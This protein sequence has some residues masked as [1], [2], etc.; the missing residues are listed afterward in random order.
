MKCGSGMAR[1]Y[2]IK[3][4]MMATVAI[5]IT[6]I[7]VVSSVGMIYLAYQR[8]LESL[9]NRGQLLARVQSAAL[10]NP[11]WE[12]NHTKVQEFLTSL[13][14]DASFRSAKVYDPDYKIVAS[15]G[16]D[17]MSTKDFSFMEPI[18]HAD[19]EGEKQTIGFLQIVLSQD[20]LMREEIGEII[21][22]TLSFL[23]LLI[24]TMI[25]I[26]IAFSRII[27]AP[28]DRVIRTIRQMAG[29][30][31]SHRLPHT[32]HK[33]FNQL[34]EA[35]NKI[36]EELQ[37]IYETIEER[38]RTLEVTIQ[39][40]EMA[41]IEAETANRAKSL[42]LANMSHELRTPLNAI[43]GYSEILQ[44]ESQGMTEGEIK[45]D[46]KKIT[47]S[48][49]HLLMLINDVLDVSKIEAGKMTLHVEPFSVQALAQEAYSIVKPM[50]EKNQNKLEI[51]IDKAVQKMESDNMKVKQILVNLL[52]NAAK[53]TMKG[54]VKLMIKPKKIKKQS[55][56]EFSV[57]DTGI[58][59]SK[60]QIEKVFSAFVQ[61]DSSTTR[62]FG[63]FG[64]GLT[65]TKEFCRIL[66]GTISVKSTPNKGSIFTV[67]LPFSYKAYKNSRKIA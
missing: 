21:N 32:E 23:M 28:L 46:L 19:D 7:M 18:I 27:T 34:A 36:T 9:R 37:N 25:A 57:K 2:S 1:V 24:A 39:A 15:I 63:G 16:E 30:D 66:G 20:E 13:K 42:F 6:A 49:R 61:A 55:F 31:L 51:V 10:V 44:E 65:I 62:K 11:M 14:D 67:L 48:G 29:G 52:S 50:V 22:S 17:V 12:L 59:M 26:Y 56:L 3:I 47:A 41:R 53:F 5:V 38:S 8:D 4:R 35:F 40:L 33:E 54:S 45:E 58:G 43:I 64:L 60:E